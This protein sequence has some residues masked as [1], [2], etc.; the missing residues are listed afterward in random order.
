MRDNGNDNAAGARP[1]RRSLLAGGAALG[2]S[3]LAVAR[4]GSAAGATG[5]GTGSAHLTLGYRPSCPTGWPATPGASFSQT[6]G[7]HTV[8]KDFTFNGKR[9]RI[10]LLPSGT[11]G[12]GF[13]PVYEDIPADPELDFQGTLASAFG[14]YYSF[15]YTGGFPG[16]GEFD[17]QSY[18]V[19]ADVSETSPR[20]SFGGGPYVVYHPDRRRGDPEADDSLQWIQVVRQISDA[21]PPGSIVDN[22]GRA[23]PYYVYGGLTSI[24]GAKAFTFHDIPQGAAEGSLKLDDTFRAEVFLAQ[25]TGIRDAAG[26]VVVKIFGGFKHGWQVRELTA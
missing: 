12:A 15:R 20:V 22:I 13:D 14:A 7:G 1:S 9:H 19:F 11:S 26:K 17:V 5:P 21:A 16:R 6:L 18:S 10:S 4:A 24:N 25:E 23:N 8:A 3:T 2:L